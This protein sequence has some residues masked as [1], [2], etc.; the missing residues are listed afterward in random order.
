MIAFTR[1]DTPTIMDGMVVRY[2]C[3]N[4]E[5]NASR[6]GISTQGSLPMVWREEDL[7]VLLDHLRRAFDQYARLS[8]GYES[9]F[10][11]EV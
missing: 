5:I 6:N 3:G 11:E 1:K 4:F 10:R 7:E 9:T 8:S 2:R